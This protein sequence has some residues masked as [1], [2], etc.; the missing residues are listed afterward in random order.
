MSHFAHILSQPQLF[1]LQRSVKPLRPI[2]DFCAHTFSI[3]HSS[4]KYISFSPSNA[5]ITCCFPAYGLTHTP[6][7]LPAHCWWSRVSTYCRSWC[8]RPS[9]SPCCR[10]PG[11]SRWCWLADHTLVAQVAHEE[12]ETDEGKDA[13]AEDGQDH[14]IRKLLHRLDQGAHNG[15]QAWGAATHTRTQ[16][17]QVIQEMLMPQVGIFGVSTS[18][19]NYVL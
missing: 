7:W 5:N 19:R 1:I 16:T 15:L 4:L 3:Q 12:L 10:W 2:S 18:T 14:H 8:T 6:T 13:Q 9:Q 17:T 11:G